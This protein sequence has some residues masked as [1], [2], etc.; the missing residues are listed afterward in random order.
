MRFLDRDTR[1]Q[2]ALLAIE[3]SASPRDTVN[4]IDANVNP[5]DLLS[6]N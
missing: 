4:A 6:T 2:V 1:F 3:R 5:T